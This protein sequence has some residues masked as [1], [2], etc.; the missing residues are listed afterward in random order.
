MSINN[1]YEYRLYSYSTCIESAVL[2]ER[3]LKRKGR[4][5]VGYPCGTIP[6]EAALSDRYDDRSISDPLSLAGPDGCVHIL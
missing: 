6:T 1:E 3:I 2:T 4:S 5:L